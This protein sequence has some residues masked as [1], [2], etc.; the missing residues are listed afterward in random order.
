MIKLLDVGAFLFYVVLGSE[1]GCFWVGWNIM[2]IKD[3]AS[4]SVS[5]DERGN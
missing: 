5:G 1:S 2:D 3:F 4:F